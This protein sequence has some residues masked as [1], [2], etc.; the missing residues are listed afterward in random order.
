MT[1]SRTTGQFDPH[2]RRIELIAP[3]AVERRPAS[4]AFESTMIPTIVPKPECQKDDRDEQAVDD[5]GYGK[6]E[7]RGA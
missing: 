1:T 7:H 2:P 4:F 3:N 5:G 6:F